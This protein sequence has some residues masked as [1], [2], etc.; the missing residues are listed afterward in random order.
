MREEKFHYLVPILLLVLLAS[1][2]GVT[3]VA[4]VLIPL[5]QVQV[6]LPSADCP[7]YSLHPR[8]PDQP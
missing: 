5:I 6:C 3:A 4:I 2:E 1:E 7:G 8:G